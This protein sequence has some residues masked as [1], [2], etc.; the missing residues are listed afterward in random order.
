VEQPPATVERSVTDPAIPVASALPATA[1]RTPGITLNIELL[2]WLLVLGG[3]A[4]QRLSALDVLPLGPAEGLRARAA[5]GLSRGVAPA[6]WTGDLTGGLTSLLFQATHASAT[7][8]RLLPALLGVAAVG[9]L[10]LYRPLIGRGAALA[11]AVLL[12]LSPVAVVTAR[13]LGPEAGALPLALALPPLAGLVLLR[14]RPIWTPVLAAAIG[15][16]LGSGSLFLV[17]VVV[18]LAWLAVETAWRDD[19]APAAALRSLRRE[20]LLVVLAGVCL[21]PGLALAVARYGAGPDGFSL[22]A[23]RAWAG[24]PPAASAAI[25][26]HYLPDVL[27]A[28]EPLAL[29]LGAAGAAL[30]LRGRKTTAGERLALVWLGI[31]SALTL[32]W[33]HR[34]PG[35]VLALTL[36]LALL[37]GLAS[38]RLAES[39]PAFGSRGGWLLL[40]AMVPASGYLLVVL[41][42]WAHTGTLAPDEATALGA[43]VSGT[44]VAVVGGAV[45]LRVPAGTLLLLIVWLGLGGF[46]LHAASSAT[47]SGGAEILTGIRTLPESEAIARRLADTAGPG[48]TVYVERRLWPALAWPLRGHPAVVFV[49]TQPGTPAAVV[50]PDTA[51][52]GAVEQGVIPVIERWSPAGWDTLGVLRWWA[53]RTP[54]GEPERL[55]AVVVTQ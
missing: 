51:G 27:L 10:A 8:A 21:V 29:T 20:P 13:T 17:A 25:P 5:F 48:G 26:W 53:Y 6:D 38:V 1:P 2:L 30:L 22:A 39:L 23:V 4:T 46:T 36:P 43:L 15:F 32:F 55:R 11:A 33:L 47:F 12:A 54:W 34:E 28:Y 14:N 52:A 19:P 31:G 40:L 35:Q 16:G 18:T 45:L 9:A 41:V 42:R 37:G 7:T 44:V 50:G 49:Q 24:P 3:A